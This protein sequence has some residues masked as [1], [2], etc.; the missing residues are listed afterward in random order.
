MG[1]DWIKWHK[2]SPLSSHMGDVWERQIRSAKAIISS[3]LKT[4]GRSLDDIS[5]ITV[6]T[7]VGGILNCRI[8]TVKT[9]NDTA[10]FQPLSPINLLTMKSKVASPP[11]G[12]LLKPD[13]HSK[14][15]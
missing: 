7:E 1:G 6:I 5:L 12:K 10:N 9:F 11:I 8:I 3:L 2:N 15:P 4:N 13:V 14:R